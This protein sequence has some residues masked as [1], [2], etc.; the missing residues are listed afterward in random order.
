MQR[1]SYSRGFFFVED[2]K[3]GWELLKAIALPFGTANYLGIF[4]IGLMLKKQEQSFFIEQSFLKSQE[5]LSLALTGSNDGY[6]DWDLKTDAVY[7]SPRYKEILGYT[8]EEFP[9]VVNS[10]EKTVYPEDLAT[11]KAALKKLIDGEAEHVEYEF[12][13]RHKDGSLRWILSRGTGVKDDDGI[14]SRLAGTQTDITERKQAEDALRLSEQKARAILDTSFQL[15][16][17]LDLDG[18]LIDVNQTAPELGRPAKVRGPGQTPLGD[19]LMV[20]FQ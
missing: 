18:T 10:W 12:R 7:F 9:D 2:L 4:L 1:W 17:M 3:T 20:V 19:P 6:W 14:V 15:F 5:R 16:G 11:A 13:M 8:D